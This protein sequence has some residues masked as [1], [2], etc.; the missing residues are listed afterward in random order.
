V[1]DAELPV[2]FLPVVV[3]KAGPPDEAVKAAPRLLLI[4][5]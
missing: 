5:E 3:P 1:V 2:E 4:F